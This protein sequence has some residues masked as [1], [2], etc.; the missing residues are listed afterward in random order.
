[1]KGSFDMQLAASRRPLQLELKAMAIRHKIFRWM[2]ITIVATFIAISSVA[3]ALQQQSYEQRIDM[4]Q[5][6][7]EQQEP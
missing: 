3:C 6:E 4:I 2:I 5:H 1:M 7:H